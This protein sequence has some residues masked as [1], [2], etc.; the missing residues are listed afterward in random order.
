MALAREQVFAVAPPWPQM[1]R[2]YSRTALLFL[3]SLHQRG[4]C[5]ETQVPHVQRAKN[6]ALASE[7][8]EWEQAGTSELQQKHPDK[9]RTLLCRSNWSL[10]LTSS[11]QLPK[12]F[13]HRFLSAAHF[14]FSCL[15][16]CSLL[17]AQ[18]LRFQFP[19]PKVTQ[20]TPLRFQ[21][22]TDSRAKPLLITA[23]LKAFREIIAMMFIMSPIIALHS[24]TN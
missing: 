20:I 9:A 13:W 3:L 7:V 10:E 21:Y 5:M 6:E 15:P 14:Y 8:W 2:V 4:L 23:L 11:R 1:N 18:F 16:L 22:N 12:S 17:S 24:K 19:A